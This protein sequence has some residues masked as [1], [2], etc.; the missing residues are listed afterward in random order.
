MP[1][2]H[3]PA[4]VSPRG[5]LFTWREKVVGVSVLI[6]FGAYVTDVGFGKEIGDEIDDGIM[7]IDLFTRATTTEND[8]PKKFVVPKK[9]WLYQK[10]LRVDS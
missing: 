2:N 5:M 3:L 9:D 4:C 7:E 8:Q 1:E 10:N 6:G